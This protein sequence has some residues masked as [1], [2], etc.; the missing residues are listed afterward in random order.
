[1]PTSRDSWK[2]GEQN[3]WRFFS[4]NTRPQWTQVRVG[5]LGLPRAPSLAATQ[6]E[7]PFSTLI[8]E[9]IPGPGLDVVGNKVDPRSPHFWQVECRG[10]TRH[11]ATSCTCTGMRLGGALVAL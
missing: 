9:R 3:R 2:Q 8:A 7:T 1:M 6:R 10:G 5:G 11:G 4:R